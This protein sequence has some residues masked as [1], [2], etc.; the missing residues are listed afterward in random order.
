MLT[1][2]A[3]HIDHVVPRSAGGQTILSNLCLACSHCNFAKGPQT[4]AL[5]PLTGR[6][7]PLFHPRE[8]RWDEHFRWSPSWAR[9]LG[10]TPVGRATVQALDMNARLL[11]RARPFWR[12]V[13]LLP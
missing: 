2:Q 9:L 13:G 1:G 4:Q 12:R 11:V 3:F 8:A 5:D 7:T 6:R 10:R